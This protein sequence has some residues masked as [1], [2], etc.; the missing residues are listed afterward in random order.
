MPASKQIDD[1]MWSIKI[2][3]NK[4]GFSRASVYKYMQHGLFPRQRHLGPGRVAWR[5]SEVRN[6]I[7][8]GPE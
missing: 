3:R 8:T 1:E 4:T 2:V 6:W 7:E 5:A